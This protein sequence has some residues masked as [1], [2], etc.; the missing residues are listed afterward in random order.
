MNWTD[1]VKSIFNR[2]SVPPP[3]PNRFMFWPTFTDADGRFFGAQEA[4]QLSVTW[5]CVSVISRSLACCHWKVYERKDGEFVCLEEDALDYILNVRPN[6]EMTAMAVKEALIFAAAMYGN[7]YAEIVRDEAGRVRELWPLDSTLVE[8]VRVN[9]DGA[10]AVAGELVY[11]C[12]HPSGT[13]TVFLKQNQVYHL[14]GPSLTGLLGENIVNRAAKTLTLA[15]AADS[16][17]RAYYANNTVVG[18]ILEYPRTLDEKSYTRLKNDWV[19]KR[20]GPG[21]AHKPVILENGMTWKPLSDSSAASSQVLE[22]RKFQVEDVARWWGVP[23]HM[24]GSLAGSQ[25]YGTNLEQ[26]GLGFVRDCLGPWA[27]RLEQEADWKLF[28]MRGPGSKKLTRIDRTPLTRGDSKTRAEVGAILRRAGVI[29]ANEWRLSEGLNRID[30]EE[31]N[32]LLVE[33]S[34]A[35]YEELEA[36]AEKAEK[37]ERDAE[38]PAPSPF[39]ARPPMPPGEQDVET[40]DDQ[41]EE[42]ITPGQA[43]NEE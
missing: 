22:A 37:A 21:N 33:A 2:G 3:D 26:L 14:R 24:I 36:R 28:P 20:S 8:P 35:T 32:Q 16:Y 17:A 9:Q 12:T 7:G 13:G 31:G 19:E 38:A 42:P 40:E 34:L 39:G 1:R 30:G 23:L 27:R 4:L 18:G 15:A 25:G 10:L 43:G 5:A 29:T 6:P 41:G 11:R